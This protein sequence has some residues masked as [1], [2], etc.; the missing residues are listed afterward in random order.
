MNVDG[1]QTE[2]LLLRKPEPKDVIDIFS[3]E[4][5]PATNRYRPAGPMKDRQEA[6][7]TLEQWRTDWAK[8]GVGYW[9]VVFPET[10]KVIGIGGIRRDYWQEQEVLNLYYRFSPPGLG[11]RLCNGGRTGRRPDSPSVSAECALRGPHSPRQ[12]PLH[13]GGGTDRPPALSRMGY[14]G[15]PGVCFTLLIWSSGAALPLVSKKTFNHNA[16]RWNTEKLL[17]KEGDHRK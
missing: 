13:P 7:E 17:L 11:P 3:I 9:A 2:H 14:S 15:T 10:K 16:S 8:D 6:E 1:V 12:H 5:D 4:G